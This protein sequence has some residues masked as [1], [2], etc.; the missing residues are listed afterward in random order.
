MLVRASA[1]AAADNERSVDDDDD[2]DDEN[3]DKK[4]VIASITSPQ[5]V[6]HTPGSFN[7]T[8]HVCL[9]RGACLPAASF[10]K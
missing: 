2:D 8:P 6:T 4:S 3:Y 9:F 1:A 7:D 10:I 5:I